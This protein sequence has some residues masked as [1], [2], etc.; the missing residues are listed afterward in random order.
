MVDVNDIR[1]QIKEY[2]D[3]IKERQEWNGSTEKYEGGSTVCWDY[4]QNFYLLRRPLDCEIDFPVC[5][6]YPSGKFLI[7]KYQKSVSNLENQIEKRPD[8]AKY[9]I[10]VINKY[11]KWISETD[12]DI[13][14]EAVSFEG[15]V[16]CEHA[17]EI[18]KGE[19]DFKVVDFRVFYS[20]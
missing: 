2:D 12:P 16:K 15:S 5:E 3:Q 7:E 6:W 1:N 10:S 14:S 17:I 11:K 8:M 20:D 13:Q 4:N 9:L 19:R 18:L